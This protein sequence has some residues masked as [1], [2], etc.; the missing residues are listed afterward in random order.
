MAFRFGRGRAQLAKIARSLGVFENHFLVEV[1][2]I[3]HQPSISFTRSMPAMST[4][5]S[6][7]VL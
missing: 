2:Q 6:S 1:A 3:R 5:I 4:S 7:F